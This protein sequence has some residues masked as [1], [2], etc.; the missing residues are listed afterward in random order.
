MIMVRARVMMVKHFIYHFLFLSWSV[1]LSMHENMKYMA[2]TG[3]T[4]A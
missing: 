4:E 1:S 3:G 2:G